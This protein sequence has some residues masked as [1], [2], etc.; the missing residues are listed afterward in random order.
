MCTTLKVMI[1]RDLPFPLKVGLQLQYEYV[2][3][4]HRTKTLL[5]ASVA[6]LAQFGKKILPSQKMFGW[7]EVRERNVSPLSRETAENGKPGQTI[8]SQ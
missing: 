1:T 7:Y 5:V 8:L 6:Q 3:T 2:S 4:H